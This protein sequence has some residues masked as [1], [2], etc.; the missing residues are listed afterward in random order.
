MKQVRKEQVL[1][2]S[3]L[4]PFLHHNDQM[5]ALDYIV[6]IESDIFMPT[7]GLGNMAKAVVGHRR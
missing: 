1:N 5:A 6:A 4:R 2:A 3:E 7:Y